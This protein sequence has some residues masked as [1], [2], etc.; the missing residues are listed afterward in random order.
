MNKFEDMSNNQ[1][2]TEIKSIEAEYEA[3]KIKIVNCLDQLESLEKLFKEANDTLV[4]RIKGHT[5][6]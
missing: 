3:L 2:I 5:N 1:I 6:E 4:K